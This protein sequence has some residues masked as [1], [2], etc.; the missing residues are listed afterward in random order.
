MTGAIDLVVRDGTIV[1]ANGRR[2]GDVV[3]SDGRIIAVQPGRWDGQAAEELDATGLLVLPGGIDT[4]VHLMDPG[5]PD[6]ETFLAGTAAAA[7]AGVTTIIE[8]T[9]GW[10]VNDVER[11]AEKRDHLLGRAFVD[12]GLAAHVWP[13]RLDQLAPLWN[14]GVAFFKIFTCTTHGV[15]GLGADRLLEVFGTFA[16]IGATTLVHCEDELVTAEAERLLKLAG[17]LDSGILTEWRSREAE[18]LA[19]TQVAAAAWLTKALVRVAHASNPTV[20]SF[21]RRARQ[22]GAA[23]SAETCPQYLFLRESE[24]HEH[25]ALR[26]FTPPA[27]IRSDEEARRMW[28]AFND[29]DADQISSDHAPSTRAQKDVDFWAAPFGLPGLDTTFPLMIDA[30]L[31]G[32]TTLERVVAAYAENPARHFRLP[33][34]GFVAPGMDADLVLLDP[35]ARWTVSVDTLR[36]KAGWSPYE[37][38]QVQGKV[39]ATVLRGHV[40]H[41]EGILAEERHG[42]FVAGPGAGQRSS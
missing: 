9:H 2:R 16:A 29:G 38:R 4:H 17:R 21:I 15:P 34:K 1:S 13:D 33:G 3:V 20:L 18:L 25:G 35:H 7:S 36:S 28:G 11:L 24:V 39:V 40:V 5:D 42:A 12:Y 27:R 32:E 19:V 37:G 31:R 26:K 6:R 14:A 8:H 41:R 10:P 22:D 23:L 30:A